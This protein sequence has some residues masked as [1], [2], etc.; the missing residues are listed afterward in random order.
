MVPAS[1]LELLV[2]RRQGPL[3]VPFQTGPTQGENI[4]VPLDYIIG[5]AKM[6]DKLRELAGIATNSKVRKVS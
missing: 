1:W 5:G 2:G 4:F 3:N 6:A